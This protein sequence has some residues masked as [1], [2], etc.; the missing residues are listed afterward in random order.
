MS[1]Q[2]TS[3]PSWFRE[4]GAKPDG[5]RVV[6]PLYFCLGAITATIIWAMTGML[7]RQQVAEAKPS[8]PKIA[9]E[10]ERDLQAVKPAPAKPVD[11]P[12]PADRWAKIKSH[13]PPFGADVSKLNALFGEADWCETKYPDDVVTFAQ[14][15]QALK[16][17]RH[18]SVFKYSPFTLITKG[19]HDGDR[20]ETRYRL[21]V[22]VYGNTIGEFWRE[23]APGDPPF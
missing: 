2:F 12:A 1:D 23:A 16:D 11:S 18:V 17:G 13:Q 4:I 10:A 22:R 6:R 9:P 20:V 8:L 19:N 3:A 15:L 5:D 7:G 14:Q 21:N